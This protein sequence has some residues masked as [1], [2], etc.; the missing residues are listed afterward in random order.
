MDNKRETIEFILEKH[1]IGDITMSQ[2]QLY[3]LRRISKKWFSEQEI[4]EIF[5]GIEQYICNNYFELVEFLKIANE[6]LAKA[7]QAFKN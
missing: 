7:K 6:K 2:S 4:L 5:D 1:V 3:R